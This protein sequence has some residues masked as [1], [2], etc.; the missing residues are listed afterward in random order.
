MY[1]FSAEC[2]KWC[3]C[4]EVM[5][6]F[7]TN[8]EEVGYLALCTLSLTSV[9]FTGYYVVAAW[10]KYVSSTRNLPGLFVC[11]QYNFLLGYATG[12]MSYSGLINAFIIALNR[13]V[14][15]PWICIWMHVVPWPNPTSKGF[16][17]LLIMTNQWYS[18]ASRPGACDV[19]DGPGLCF[20]CFHYRTYGLD[21]NIC[22]LLISHTWNVSISGGIPIHTRKSNPQ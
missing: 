14:V 15:H 9:S 22:I 5:G 12:Y 6:H 20:V 11:L 3:R 21:E 7:L 8:W 4:H 16:S 13:L 18:R 10:S 19:L 2:V 17:D 1:V